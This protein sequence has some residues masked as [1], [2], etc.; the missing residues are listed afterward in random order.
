MVLVSVPPLVLSLV[1]LLIATRTGWLP[2]GGLNIDSHATAAERIFET[3]RSL[4]L[5][6]FA[7]ALPIAASVERLQAAAIADALRE[8]CIRAALARGVSPGRA[9]WNHAFRLSL[10]PVLAIFGLIVGTVLSGSL[11]VE[12]VMSWPGVGDLMY[13][14]L[15]S[16][17]LHL[18]G[19]CAATASVFLAVGVL[20]SDVT[21]AA[22]DPRIRSVE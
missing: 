19:G 16:R 12:I 20:L 7:L 22:V 11:I 1:F 14:A 8:P 9:I 15:V 3:L 13:K 5:P 18:A 2:A 10:K 6:A 21:L 4:I 17:D